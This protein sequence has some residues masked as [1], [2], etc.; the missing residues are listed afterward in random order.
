MGLFVLV[1]GYSYTY[2]GCRQKN[3]D[4]VGAFILC[5]LNSNTAIYFGTQTK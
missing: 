3:E 2:K 5:Y 4:A 1:I